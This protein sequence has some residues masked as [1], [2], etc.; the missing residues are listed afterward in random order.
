[1]YS[2]LR[3]SYEVRERLQRRERE[4]EAV[5]RARQYRAHRQKRRASLEAVL[6]KLSTAR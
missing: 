6:A 3:Y 2:Y 5:L 4:V 1:M